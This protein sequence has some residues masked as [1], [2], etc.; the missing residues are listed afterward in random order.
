MTETRRLWELELSRDASNLPS[1]QAATILGRIYFANGMDSMGWTTWTQALAI[2]GKLGLF[3]TKTKFN[4][5]KERISKT[6]TAWG[7][8]S[9]Q[10]Y[11]H[12][13]PS[14]PNIMKR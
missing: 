6:I 5:E 12:T 2:A 4:N 13:I 9:Q 14:A 8:F 10:A 11:E 7:I 1:A 3:T